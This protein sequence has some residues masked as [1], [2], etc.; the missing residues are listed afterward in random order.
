MSGVQGVQHLALSDCVGVL[1][2]VLLLAAASA[3][4]T[5]AISLAITDLSTTE[6]AAAAAAAGA[7]TTAAATVLHTAGE[8]HS[9]VA[10]H[11]A[12]L[13]TCAMHKG[14][15]RAHWFYR[16]QMHLGLL[17]F[18]QETPNRQSRLL[19]FDHGR[20][21]G[22]WAAGEADPGQLPA[23]GGGQGV[24]AA[25]PRAP[26]ERRTP[27]RG[28]LLQQHL[29]HRGAPGAAQLRCRQCLPVRL[30]QRQGSSG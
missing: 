8:P 11:M 20:C 14:E 19:P 29:L 9:M 24:R 16:R 17:N 23:G 27:G 12:E 6:G 26:P 28:G 30:G 22:G 18:T 13:T 1:P 4:S 21:A 2:P 5:A 25:G 10:V 15:P 3:A 7:S